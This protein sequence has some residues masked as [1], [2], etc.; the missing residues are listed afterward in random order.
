[1]VVDALSQKSSVALAHIQTASV[2]L[3]LDMN[4]IGVSLDYDGYGALIASFMVRPMLVDQIRGKWMKNDEL[5]KEVHKIMNGDIGENFQ[6]TQDGVLTIRGRV[7]V[8]DVEGLRRLI[9]EK[10]HCSAYAMHPSSIR[11]YWTIKENY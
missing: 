10:T 5:V 7:C 4:T 9:M 3:L 2:P 11:M 6:I 1:M 8:L